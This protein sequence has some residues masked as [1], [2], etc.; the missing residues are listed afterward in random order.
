MTQGQGWE[1]AVELR[2]CTRWISCP[3]HFATDLEIAN[4]SP[5]TDEELISQSLRTLEPT[6]ETYAPT[7]L[8]AF[9]FKRRFEA[10]ERYVREP[11][12]SKACSIG[13]RI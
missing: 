11:G 3:T 13:L 10:R 8:N 5:A 2:L 9:A 1:R 12:M 6:F 7:S 4:F